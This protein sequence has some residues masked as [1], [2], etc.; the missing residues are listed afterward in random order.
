MKFKLS[1]IF[2]MST[3][4]AVTP[5]VS[6]VAASC[7]NTHSKK[8]LKTKVVWIGIDGFSANVWKQ[9]K[10]PNIA[11]LI[12]NS[13]YS[14]DAQDI[15]P[16]KTYPNW[17]ALFTSM[18]PNKTGIQSNPGSIFNSKLIKKPTKWNSDGKGVAYSIFD[19]IKE[20]TNSKSS[21]IYP[22]VKNFNITNIISKGSAELYF[23]EG[24]TKGLSKEKIKMEEFVKDKNISSS[25]KVAYILSELTDYDSIA[26]AGEFLVNGKSDFIFSYV[27]GLDIRGHAFGW[28]S[29]EY[30]EYL[31]QVDSYIGLLIN[32]IKNYNKFKNTIFVLTADHGGV[33]N[34]KT[35][36]EDTLDERTVP[37]IIHNRNQKTPLNLGKI[38]NLD[39]APTL[40]KLLDLKQC[41]DW[42]G[43]ILNLK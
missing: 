7:G 8:E 18:K 32:K 39:V 11:K 41:K 37:I 4:V 5:V 31:N 23:A 30:I 6:M 15:M 21:F 13:N 3:A 40:S 22:L 35:H 34:K 38:S 20:Q 27:T 9:H 19:A 33:I 36:G 29:K 25:S 12:S 17:T 14:L 10:T 1:K 24:R 16:S 26:K 2:L 43:K 28:G 42:E